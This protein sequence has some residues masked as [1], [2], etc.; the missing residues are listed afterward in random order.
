[1]SELSRRR[2]LK[3]GLAA[4]AA[5]GASV[6]L[7]PV[8]HASEFPEVPG[9][10]GDRRANEL[11][12]AYEMEFSYA[13]SAEVVAA[14]GELDAAAQGSPL[15]LLDLYIQTREQ[16]TYPESYLDRIRRARHAFEVFSVVQLDLFDRYYPRDERALAWSFV[17]MGNGVLYDPR[18][19][20]PNEIHMMTMDNTSADGKTTTSWHFWHAVNRGLTLLGIDR[21]RWNRLDRLVGLGWEVQSTTKPAVGQ[22]NPPIACHTA[23][24]LIR[25]WECRTPGEMDR[26]F[27]SFPYPAP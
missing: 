2:V 18:M 22:V 21:A 11:W 20:H 24:R 10:R 26:A 12:Y 27:Q 16:G 1:M 14:Y 5:V 8:A 4:T 23:E 7:A 6:L 19:P 17:H 15:S 25:R 3:S 13:P 9:M